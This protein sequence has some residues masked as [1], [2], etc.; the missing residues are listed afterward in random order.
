MAKLERIVGH[1]DPD[2]LEDEPP[3]PAEKT[4]PA[5]AGPS[6]A[7]E[8]TEPVA[9]T[10]PR[11]GGDPPAEEPQRMLPGHDGVVVEFGLLERY[12]KVGEGRRESGK[13]VFTF[14][15]T[16]AIDAEAS[17]SLGRYKFFAYGAGGSR[18]GS[19]P[20]EFLP[21]N[22]TRTYAKDESIKIRF[23]APSGLAKIERMKFQA[24]PE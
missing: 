2:E 12:G 16:R 1:V 7:D 6:A 3:Q 18:K 4:P 17:E 22:R 20:F 23:E 15:T 10:T 21:K 5:K 19:V 14:D 13:F 11:D 8:N 24:F 9:V